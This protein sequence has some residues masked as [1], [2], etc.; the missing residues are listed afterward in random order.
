LSTLPGIAGQAR[1]FSTRGHAQGFVYLMALMTMGALSSAS[2]AV[3][4]G[5]PLVQGQS[6]PSPLGIATLPPRLLGTYLP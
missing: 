2:F 1:P 4:L 3:S 6:C 5:G